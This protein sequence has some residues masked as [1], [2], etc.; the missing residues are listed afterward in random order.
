MSGDFSRVKDH[1]EEQNFAPDRPVLQ[2][3]AERGFAE[4]KLKPSKRSRK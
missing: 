3:Q 1:I 4:H 2:N